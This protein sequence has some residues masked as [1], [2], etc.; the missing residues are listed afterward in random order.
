MLG[1]IGLGYRY[2]EMDDEVEIETKA[3]FLELGGRYRLT[4]RLSIGPEVQ[5][6][7]GQDVSFSDVGT[8]SDDKSSA[9]F[10]GLRAFYD[11][12]SPEEEFMFRLGA[13]GLTDINLSLI[14][15]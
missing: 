6:L 2:D 15:I 4:E 8:N 9:L 10:L 5:M 11:F 12:S 3:F 1:D 7:L 14:H 13:Q